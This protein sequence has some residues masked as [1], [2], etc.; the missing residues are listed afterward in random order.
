M[1]STTS[2]T[3]SITTTA[4]AVGTPTLKRQSLIV[5][6]PATAANPVWFGGS[7]VT[8]ANG[9]PVNAGETVTFTNDGHGAHGSAE[10]YAIVATTAVTVQYTEL[11]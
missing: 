8:T 4:G 2:N 1:A 6:V 7:N 11:T 10:W 3:Q 9:F 5:Y